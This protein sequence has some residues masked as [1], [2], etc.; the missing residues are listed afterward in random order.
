VAVLHRVVDRVYPL[1]SIVEAG[2]VEIQDGLAH[3]QGSEED[4]GQ[5]AGAA[6]PCLGAATRAAVLL[7]SIT[8]VEEAALGGSAGAG[9]EGALVEMIE[10]DHGRIEVQNELEAP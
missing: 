10:F 2:V 6:G 3:S 7:A 5:D 1:G 8:D 9:E 4:L